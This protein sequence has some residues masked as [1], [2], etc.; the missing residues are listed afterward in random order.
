[1][2]TTT[3]ILTRNHTNTITINDDKNLIRY[4]SINQNQKVKLK[5]L[6]YDFAV[7]NRIGWNEISDQFNLDRE[8]K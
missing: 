5:K 3:K 2:K 8:P 4:D 6:L 7:E 1:M